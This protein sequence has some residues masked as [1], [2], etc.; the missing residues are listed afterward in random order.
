MPPIPQLLDEFGSYELDDKNLVQDCVMAVALAVRT[1][2]AG[3]VGDP[4]DE[5]GR[6]VVP[7]DDE[8]GFCYRCDEQ[9]FKSQLYP[10]PLR[11]GTRLLCMACSNKEKIDT[12]LV[13]GTVGS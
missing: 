7:E 1:V 2:Y 9:F 8:Q 6:A 11:E 4:I 3:I 10:W 5:M 13:G 12:G